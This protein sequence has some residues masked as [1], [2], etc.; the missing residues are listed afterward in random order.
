MRSSISRETVPVLFINSRTTIASQLEYSVGGVVILND[1]T[2]R[3]EQ[4]CNSTPLSV[5]FAGQKY[6]LFYFDLPFDSFAVR[7][8]LRLRGM[9]KHGHGNKE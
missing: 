6:K 2:Q 1:I 4:V 3:P 5:A 9:S 7:D 8:F